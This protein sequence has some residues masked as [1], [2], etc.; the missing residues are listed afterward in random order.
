MRPVIGGGAGYI[1]FSAALLVLLL[2]ALYNINVD[3]LM[4]VRKNL[5]AES[6]RRRYIGWALVAAAFIERLAFVYARSR[7]L[8]LVGSLGWLLLLSFVTWSMLRS[9]LK[10]KAVT[11]ETISM[12]IS[13]YLLLGFTWGFLYAVIFQL[14]PGAFNMAGLPAPTPGHPAN[15]QPLLPTLRLFQPDHPLHRRLWR[16]HSAEHASALRRCS[17]GHNRTILPGHL[18]RAAGRDADEPKFKSATQ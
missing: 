11:S 17:G 12:S 16:H 18:G 2:I 9:V 1:V 7:T 14:R 13:V 8:D 15:A 6:R 10:Q 3:E 4:G 5:L